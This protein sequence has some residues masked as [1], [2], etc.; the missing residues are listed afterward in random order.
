MALTFA[1]YAAPAGWQRPVAVA[2]VVALAAVNYRGITRTARLAAIL[3]TGSL[4]A[5]AV[6]IAACASGDGTR[7]GHLAD[8]PGP[9]G[10][11]GILQ[12][13]GLLFFA[14]A[15]YARI[16][17]LGEEVRDPQRTIPRAI[18]LALGVTVA[19]YAAVGVTA[20][21]AAGPDTLAHSHS[22]LT[23]AVDAAGARWAAPVVRI[24]A[25]IAAAGSLLALVAGVGRTALA[26]ARN[27]DLPTRLAAVH[28]R[29]AV[30]HH[31]E[32]A[33]A[34]VVIVLVATVDLRGVIG[35]SS[36]AVLIYYGIANASAFTQRGT[37]RRWPRW[38]NVLGV[39]GCAALVV[40]LPVWSVVAGAAMFAVGLAGR[41]IV[42][43]A[44]AA[45]RGP[46]SDAAQ[47][48]AA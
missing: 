5:L 1:A 33:V 46:G 10:A 45:R 20:L 36:F 26:M 16:A 14:F 7:A 12:S 2:A 25:V 3:V 19:V 27:R 21:L 13:A 44:A 30:P 42:T 48:P 35:F 29:F 24:G 47:G 31:A 37:D 40:T 43:R 39:L 11:Y 15:G 34:A 8:F 28:P 9:G 18:P 4:T 6:V 22:P 23:A 17:T 32:I 38:L 41:W